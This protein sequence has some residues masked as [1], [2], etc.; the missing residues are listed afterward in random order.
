MLR[1]PL[2]FFDTTPIGRILNRFS[3]DQQTIDEELP[4]SLS[5]LISNAYNVAAVLFVVAFVTPFFIAILV[6]LCKQKIA[7]TFS[8]FS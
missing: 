7:V 8:F 6:P 3:K 5:D 4:E 2:S 1:A